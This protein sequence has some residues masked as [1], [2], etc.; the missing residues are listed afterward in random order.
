M[1]LIQNKKIAI[2]CNAGKHL[3]FF[4]LMLCKV[5]NDTTVAGRMNKKE[6]EI[7]KKINKRPSLW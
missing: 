1:A 7:K 4:I 2:N 5:S 6:R 3:T